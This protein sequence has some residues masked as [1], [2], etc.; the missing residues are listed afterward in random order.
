M[1]VEKA[2]GAIVA[3]DLRLAIKGGFPTSWSLDK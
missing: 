1:V 2:E 3:A